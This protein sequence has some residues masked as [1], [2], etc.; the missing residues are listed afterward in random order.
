M[1]P[2][3][4][5]S[6]GQVTLI[7]SRSFS[8]WFLLLEYNASLRG[9]WS[10]VNPDAPDTANLITS[11]PELPVALD[12]LL[13]QLD[14]QRR[15]V[16][17]H[18]IADPRP[19]EEKGICP[20]VLPASFTDV[21]EELAIRQRSY[22]LEQAAWTQQATRYQHLWDWV[23]KTVNNKILAPHLEKL[24]REKQL[25]LQNVVRALKNE[26]C[27]STENTK[28]LARREYRQILHQA[29]YGRTELATWYNTWRYC[30][31]R[32]RSFQ[33][34]E[35]EGYLATIDF[36]EAIQVKYAPIWAEQ[37]ISDLTARQELGEQVRT[38]DQYGK[39]FET[40]MWR[41]QES[42][43]VQGAFATLGARASD[44]QPCPCKKNR[45]ERHPWRA[46][47]CG[48]LEQA[49]TGNCTRTLDPPLK[50]ED[51]EGIKSRLQLKHFSQIRDKLREKGWNIPEP[52]SSAKLYPGS[53]SA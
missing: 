50:Q 32:A 20:L 15:A 23:N 21:K 52:T 6:T 36:L 9:I 4:S 47:N 44:S 40:H 7:D 48:Y 53:V 37:Q 38:L 43:S 26:L 35:V 33:L 18:W 31:N 49:I 45:S 24:T 51:I 28:N 12:T 11:P 27:T 19:E 3:T 10:Y 22:A 13:A 17:D 14:N 29:R 34:D 41:L 39:I 1:D 42:Q 46:V 25:S 5:I 8:Q 16:L 30:Y 2:N